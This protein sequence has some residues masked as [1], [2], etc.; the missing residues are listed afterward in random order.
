MNGRSLALRPDRRD[1]AADQA[2]NDF[3]SHMAEI[4]GAPYPMRLRLTVHA[5]VLMLVAAI[6]T[7]SVVHLDRVVSAPGRLVSRTPTLLVQPLESTVL[8]EIM[9]RPGDQVTKG[10]LLVTLDPTLSSADLSTLRSNRQALV[11]LVARLEAEQAEQPLA[12]PDPADQSAMTEYSIWKARTAE[13]EARLAVFDQKIQATN[14]LIASGLRDA[15]HYRARLK[16]SEEIEG[17]RSELARKEVGSRLNVLIAQDSKAEVARNLSNSE[18]QVRTSRHEVESLAA[19]REAYMQEWRSQLTT[20]LATKRTEL[21][22]V[23]DGLSKAEFRRDLVELRAVADATVVSVADAGA[24]AVVPSGEVLV[25]LMPANAML[26][27]EADVAGM[28]QGFV[29]VGDEV[30][31]KL[32]AYEFTRHGTVRAEVRSISENSFAQRDDG[33]VAPERFYKVR[34]EIKAVEL[35]NVPPSLRLIPGMP[36]NADIVVGSRPII[37][38]LLDRIIANSQEGLREP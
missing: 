15:E 26:E 8:R 14:G 35:R 10:D 1:N 34:A 37:A 38:N 4:T 12:E 30:Q 19:E 17:M 33:T 27:V 2:I 9:V 6:V 23:E 18:Q 7:S 32:N 24:G 28:D 22:E 13:R 11:A 20:L 36:L 29:K 3:Q 25:T 5:L 31:V 16:V 21:S